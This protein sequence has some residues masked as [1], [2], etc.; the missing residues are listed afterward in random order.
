MCQKYGYKQ[1]C[2]FCLKRCAIGE[3]SMTDAPRLCDDVAIKFILEAGDTSYWLK[4]IVRSGLA[5]DP[6]DVLRDLESAL[7]VFREAF[8]RC[9]EPTKSQPH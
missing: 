6:V 9:Y 8:V 2:S 7:T 4:G 5:R 1:A 3:V